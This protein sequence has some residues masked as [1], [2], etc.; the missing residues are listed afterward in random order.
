M[1]SSGWTPSIVPNGDDET[2]YLVNDDL[3]RLGAVWREADAETSDFETVIN[4]LMS[5][6]YSDPIRV[7]TFNTV[8][9][10]SRDVSEQI[11]HEM[12]RRCDLQMRDAA[13]AHR[14]R[15]FS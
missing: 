10:W 11:A 12:R 8:E 14:Q 7:I 13:R 9:R 4:D 3:G 15:A 5:G 6:Q 1:R 2:V